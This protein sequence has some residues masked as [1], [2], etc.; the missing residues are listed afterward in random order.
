[1]SNK[2]SNLGVLSYVQFNAHCFEPIPKSGGLTNGNVHGESNSFNEVTIN[3]EMVVFTAITPTI[4][5]NSY[6][7]N[8]SNSIIEIDL[9]NNNRASDYRKQ[10][11]LS[12]DGLC[13]TAETLD[14][15]FDFEI[16]AGNQSIST[17]MTLVS[18]NSVESEYKQVN[19]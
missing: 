13:A 9:S 11:E 14:F 15:E 3:D 10:S 6:N 17:L 18:I 5:D 8:A 12:N 4:Y 7:S 1:M 2:L 16:P 19:N